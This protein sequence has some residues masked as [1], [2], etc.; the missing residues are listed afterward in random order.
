MDA[1]TPLPIDPQQLSA[2]GAMALVRSVAAL[3]VLAGLLSACS[4]YDPPD[5]PYVAQYCD[6]P[7]EQVYGG[8]P[9]AIPHPMR[10][11][12]CGVCY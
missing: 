10:C 3:L 1:S 2:R 7:P 4:P 8:A 6:Y 11:F 9:V 12:Q 5:Q